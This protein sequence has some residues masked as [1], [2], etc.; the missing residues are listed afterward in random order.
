MIRTAFVTDFDG[1]I[2][3]D[4]FF[5]LVVEQYFA[6][7]KLEPWNQYL[8]GK[9]S[10]FNALN[11]IFQSLHITEKELDDFITKI[12]IDEHFL[13]TVKLCHSKQIPIYITSAGCDYYIKRTI[14]NIINK[15]QI[16]L[17]TN[18]GEYSQETGLQMIPPPTDSLFYNEETGISKTA[19]VQKLKEEGY[20][21]IFAGDGPPDFAPAKLSDVIF[22]RKHLLKRCQ[23]EGIKTEN[24]QS[25]KDIYTFIKGL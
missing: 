6:K 1:T 7:D 13:P 21:V 25:Y 10:H 2:T 15:Y 20:R 16:T 24:F 12:N 23:K 14:G 9:L 3:F 22:A 11:Q 18:K 17:I 5:W 19:V 4:D 8:D